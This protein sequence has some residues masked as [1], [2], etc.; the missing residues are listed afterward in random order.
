MNDD[1][2]HHQLSQLAIIHVKKTKDKNKSARWFQI[3]GLR[4]P[5]GLYSA[6]IYIYIAEESGYLARFIPDFG[7]ISAAFCQDHVLRLPQVLFLLYTC[8]FCQDHVLRLPQVL[9][10]LY[11]CSFLPGPRSSAAT[12]SFPPVHLRLTGPDQVAARTGV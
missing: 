4:L 7:R 2:V 3:F 10:L 1:N 6:Y 8:S 12:G 5:Q 9:F 11:T